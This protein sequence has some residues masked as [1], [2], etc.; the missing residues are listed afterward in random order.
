[1]N[2]LNGDG[3]DYCIFDEISSIARIPDVAFMHSTLEVIHIP[4][5]VVDIGDQCFMCCTRLSLVVFDEDSK[6]QRIG[7]HAFAYSNIGCLDLPVNVSD[8]TGLS[9]VGISKISVHSESNHL[10]LSHNG[11]LFNKDR[12]ILIRNFS[13]EASICIPASIRSISDG[14]FEDS[15]NLAEVSFEDGSLVTFIPDRAF[16]GC[17]MMSSVSLS[18]NIEIIGKSSFGSCHSLEKFEIKNIN[19]LQKIDS[20]AFHFCSGL[21]QIVIPRNVVF[22]SY[23]IDRRVKVKFD[24]DDKEFNVVFS[25]NG[26]SVIDAKSEDDDD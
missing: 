15:H 22:G 9:F 19:V 23:A 11:F 10:Y 5:S 25:D 2:S 8:V 24:N 21:K 20:F 4:R 14:A 16:H 12:S 13:N 18:Q 6:L 26:Y 7:R 1:M 17:F 3:T